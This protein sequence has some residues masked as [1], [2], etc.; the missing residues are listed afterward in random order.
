MKNMIKMI[1]A[2]ALLMTFMCSPALAQSKIGIV[3][4]KTLFDNY[5]KTK[6]AQASIQ[7]RAEQLD[8]DDKSMKADLQKAAEDYQ[9][10]LENA[11]DQAV[12]A[13]E[14]ANRRKEADAKLKQLQENQAALENYEREAQSTLSDKRSQMREKILVEI[15]TAVT[16]QAKVNGYSIVID[17]AAETVN[18]TPVLVY[19]DGN[20][21]LTDAVL[22]QLNA[23]APVDTTP[24]P[25]MSSPTPSLL[26]TNSP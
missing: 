3:N 2:G 18:S 12:S 24:A 4:L 22:K 19:T 11:N 25:P 26:S 5:Y 6:L 9:Q 17:S 23:G 20:N 1:F 15:Q 7:D 10:L 21:D 14:R 16:L 13:D 8:K